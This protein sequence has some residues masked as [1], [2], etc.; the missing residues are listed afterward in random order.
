MSS[1]R[2]ATLAHG[3]RPREVA[4][5]Q[6]VLTDEQLEQGESFYPL[7][8]RAC[9]RCWLVQIP[10]FVPPEEIFT[11]YAYFSSYSDSWVEHARRYVDA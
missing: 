10:Q 8:V 6:T 4:P 2:G 5:L 1:L 3:R 9:E 11:E 7:H